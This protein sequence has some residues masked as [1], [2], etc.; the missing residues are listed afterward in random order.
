MALD[1]Q[2][3]DP[4][5]PAAV[6][7]AQ[8]T[9]TRRGYREE[10]VRDFL[11]QV[12]VEMARLLERER[13]LQ[14]ELQAL[15]S[16]GAVDV[17]VLDETTITELLGAEAARVLSA[18]RDAAQAMRDRAAES[19]EQMVKEASREATRMLE[20]SRIE[21][22]RRRSDVSSEAEQEL[23]LAKQ[24]GREMVAEV[25][26]YRE[27]V[28]ADLAKRTDEARR[29]LERLV[30][31][32]E[33][34]LSAFERA[35]H[36]AT[37]VVGDLVEFDDVLRETGIVPPLVPPD[38]P[39]P[40]RPTSKSDTPI[41]DAKQYEDELGTASSAVEDASTPVI[42]IAPPVQSEMTNV[43]ESDEMVEPTAES[44]AE[45]QHPLESSTIDRQAAETSS[46]EPEQ[47]EI[48]PSEV[49]PSEPQSQERIAPVVSIFD[50]QRRKASEVETAPTAHSTSPS[51]TQSRSPEHPV[52]ERVEAQPEAPVTSVVTNRVD[53]IFERLRSSSAQRVAT[54][55][56][57][58]LAESASKAKP[59]RTT[60]DV[61]NKAVRPRPVD[62]S[63]FQRRAEV[64]EAVLEKMKRAAKR[65]MADDENAVLTHVGTKRS[66]L[67]L[68]AM[69][70]NVNDHAQRFV[71]ALREDVISIAVDGARSLS[72]SRRSDVLKG[73]MGGG[74]LEA[75][76]AFIVNDLIRP[77]HERLA[78]A[79]EQSSGDRDE[80]LKSAR[81][82]FA[83]WKAQRLDA[84]VV[85]VAHLAYARGL[86]VGCETSSHVC[87]AVDPN[88]PACADAEDNALAGRVRRGDAFPTGHDRPLAHAGCRC[89]VVPLNK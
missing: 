31:E 51:T 68:D 69:L 14:N 47:T 39:P 50:R 84:I 79:I 15:Q 21:A 7:S 57:H 32:R 78:G 58:E 42:D 19:A 22:S 63:I 33:R 64:I 70:P 66:A 36:A 73:V 72:D 3:P 44:S 17:T 77:L 30:H 54:E 61:E 20:E 56:E 62:S 60:D 45:E 26:A 2:R 8:F 52:F 29:E 83:E 88:G 27:R 18:A 85:D 41:F 10:E 4:S 24:Q 89:L 11:R 53:E 80:L 81:S 12:S 59:P 25:R 65:T 82:E 46:H 86:F 13:F 38:A 23:E 28:L 40:P 5:S 34:L 9:V 74:L 43:S 87:W 16:R 35:R 48:T 67:T 1:F 37:D 75:V 76:T 55:T 49:T 71:D 6:A